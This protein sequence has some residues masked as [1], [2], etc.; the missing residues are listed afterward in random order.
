M[1]R[2]MKESPELLDEDFFKRSPLDCA[3]ELIGC[4]LEW[5]GCGGVIVE[6]EA[7]AAKGD[8]A[9]HAHVRPSSR[10]FISEHGAG[11]A[12]V[13]L[14]YGVHWLFNLLVKGGRSD[15]FVLIRAMEPVS[16]IQRMRRRRRR[17][18]V[19]DLCSGP[20]K[21]TQ[22][23]GMDGSLHGLAL[24]DVPDFLL[25]RESSPPEDGPTACRRVGISRAVER[26]WRFVR[27]GSPCLSVRPGAE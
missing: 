9:C 16:G 26:K 21:L 23:L 8:E 20:G 10:L 3:R 18:A 24:L 4:R 2:L 5:K 1:D 12:Y 25:S 14:N 15:G 11:T 19:A 13:Y 17:E 22:A 27:S 7:Y 6:T